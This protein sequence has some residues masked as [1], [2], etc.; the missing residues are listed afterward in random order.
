MHVAVT[1]AIG[2]LTSHRQATG[3]GK[4]DKAHAASC[5]RYGV[6]KLTGAIALVSV[7]DLLKDARA[8]DI[9]SCS[10]WHNLLLVVSF[11]Q[12]V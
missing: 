12:Y 3:N 7:K 10:C 5:G 4:C 8:M 1:C 6:L 9:T 2:T 11:Q